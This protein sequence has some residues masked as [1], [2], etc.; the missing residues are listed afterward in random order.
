M[1]YSETTNTSWFA[2]IGD[3]IKGVLVGLLLF[4]LSFV[5]L[6][7]NEGRTVQTTKSLDEGASAVVKLT[8]AKLNPKY[9]GKLVYISGKADTQDV[10]VDDSFGVSVR[11]IKLSKTVLT[12]QWSEDVKTETTKEVGGNEK[13]TKTYTYKKI[14]NER[15]IDSSAFK[16]QENH[17]NPTDVLYQSSEIFASAVS[18]GEFVLNQTQIR[19]IGGAAVLPISKL[20]ENL[21]T[22]AKIANN[23]IYISVGEA[24]NTATTI[25]DQKISFKVV[26]PT[27]VSIV[28]RQVQNSFEPYSTQAGDDISMIDTGVVSADAMFV[29]A[30]QDNTIFAWILRFVGFFMMFGGLSMIL[31]PLSVVADVLPLLGDIVAMGVGFISFVVALCFSLLTIGVAWIFYRPLLGISLVVVGFAIS[32]ALYYGRKKQ[33]TNHKPQTT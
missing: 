23:T 20:P 24:N 32:G 17:Q 33:T 30:Q 4:L 13:T 16:Q 27:V 12:Y 3:S 18:L 29:S 2:R 21:T 25:G 14:W 8:S 9:D 5:L 28:A 22:N 26:K 10:L 1:S 6:F 11:A 15:L 31:K 7:W 19:S